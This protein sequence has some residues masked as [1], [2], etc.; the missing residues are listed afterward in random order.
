MVRLHK[1]VNASLDELEPFIFNEWKFHNTKALRLQTKMS[2]ED[3]QR[4]YLDMS[5]LNWE[6]YFHSLALGV[7]LYLNN[8]KI[9]T[10]G[11][12]KIKD[13]M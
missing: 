10:L 5:S 8:E 11:A 6:Q 2:E 7:R 3:K 4:F 1:K 13:N 9:T 12:A